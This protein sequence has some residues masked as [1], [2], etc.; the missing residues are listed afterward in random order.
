M[1]F[2]ETKI[3]YDGSHYICIPHREGKKKK[4]K[5]AP[6]RAEPEKKAPER[7]DDLPPIIEGLHEMTV[8]EL[9]NTFADFDEF[10]Y[11]RNL[12][13]QDYDRRA[14]FD[15]VYEETR[16]CSKKER[17]EKLYEAIRPI[18]GDDESARLFVEEN[19]ERVHRNAVA[20]RVRMTR[21]VNL[22]NFNYFVTFTYDDRLHTEDSFRKKLKNTLSHLSSRDK[23]KY[24][25]VW[26]RAPKSGRLHFHGIFYIP[27][28]TM[29]GELMEVRDYN[30]RKGEMQ[31]TYQC[32]YFAQRF[33]RVD[34]EPIDDNDKGHTL[35]YLMKY[36]EK[37][38]EKIVYSKGLP[39][40]FIS[41]VADED[42]ICPYDE[43]ELKY[44]LSD[45]FTCYDYGEIMGTVSPEVI[46]KMRKSN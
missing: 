35:A 38:G 26:E 24:I 22:Q 36:I 42:V 23:W 11:L 33:G 2:L 37:D 32:A 3:Y 7:E 34:F 28:G 17:R 40:Y 5:K 43:N 46:E 25:G 1:P 15:R 44:V 31:T 20:K 8:D 19:L 10:E 41:D 12:H 13:P 21:K 27:Q 30:T 9:K 29:P 14:V 4:K 6:I 16:K 39:Q 18:S 45:K